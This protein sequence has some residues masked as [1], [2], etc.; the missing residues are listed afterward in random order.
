MAS[1]AVASSPGL[2][3][4]ERDGTYGTAPGPGEAAGPSDQLTP[5]VK[6]RSDQLAPPAKPQK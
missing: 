6:S 3:Q 2:L 1:S 5:K 4:S